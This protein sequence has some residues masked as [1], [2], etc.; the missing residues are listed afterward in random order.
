MPEFAKWVNGHLYDGGGLNQSQKELRAFYAALCKLCQ[1]P[2][3]SGDGFWGLRYFNNDVRFA[4]LPGDV[5]NCPSATIP[6][7]SHGCSMIGRIQ[8][9]RRSCRFVIVR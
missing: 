5:P 7:C 2:T 9:V 8:V 3:I 6:F 4:E 1:D